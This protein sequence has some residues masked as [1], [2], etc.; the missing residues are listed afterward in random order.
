MSEQIVLGSAESINMH[1]LN[2]DLTQKSK[3]DVKQVG[4]SGYSVVTVQTVASRPCSLELP[5]A[6]HTQRLEHRCRQ[7]GPRVLAP[8]WAEGPGSATQKYTRYTGSTT[9]NTPTPPF[10]LQIGS[11][12][13]TQ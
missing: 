6:V 3:H 2:Y 10:E 13:L 5:A 1:P 4:N 7:L 8:A 12:E 11:H 9:T